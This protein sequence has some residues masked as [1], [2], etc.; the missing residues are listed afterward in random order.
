MSACYRDRM[1]LPAI[2]LLGLLTAGVAGDAAAKPAKRKAKRPRT[3][4]P[5]DFA[6]APSFKY[7]AMGRGECLTELAHRKIPYEPV[8]EA[9]GVVIPI[10]LTGP[11]SGVRFRTELPEKERRSSP[12]EV[13]D[14]RLALA[15]SDFAAVL[16]KHDVEEVLIFSAWRPPAKTWPKDKPAVRHPGGLALDVRKL[17][18]KPG[19][20]GKR[21]DLEILRDWV[22]KPEQ[23][24]CTK[25]GRA[26]GRPEEQEL[27]AI[28]CEA[29]DARMFTSQLSPNYDAA[30]KNHF[31][32]EVRPEVSWRLVL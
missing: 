26:S 19:A 24:P 7:G 31:H 1:R 30:H 32:L 20:D 4:A 14:C 21:A 15:I 28:F 25:D 9:R 27:H 22:P 18:K 29:N 17:V 6:K 12:F 11:V 8:E 3:A 13:M 5:A 10:R 23:D 16:A 2:L